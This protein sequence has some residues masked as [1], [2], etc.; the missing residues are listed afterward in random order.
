M[1]NSWCKMP[2]Y[3]LYL[4]AP[5]IMNVFSHYFVGGLQAHIQIKAFKLYMQLTIYLQH[6]HICI[7]TLYQQYIHY[8]ILYILQIYTINDISYIC[9]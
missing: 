3:S 6:I 4:R 9:N 7:Y 1:A 2:T 5:N 8:V